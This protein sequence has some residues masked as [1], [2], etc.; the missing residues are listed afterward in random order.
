MGERGVDDLGKVEFSIVSDRGE[1]QLPDAFYRIKKYC[2]QPKLT[3]FEI[4]KTLVIT[5]RK[6]L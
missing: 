2:F 6:E 3:D 4:M 1:C 5:V